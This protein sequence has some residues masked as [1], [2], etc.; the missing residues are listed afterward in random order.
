MILASEGLRLEIAQ[1]DADI[2]AKIPKANKTGK[3]VGLGILGFLL[4]IPWF[5]MDPKNADKTEL[6]AMRVRRSRLA[7]IAGEK[8]CDLLVA[9]PNDNNVDNVLAPWGPMPVVSYKYD[10]V[11]K[12]GSLS[13][14]ISGKGIEARRWIM[15]NIGEICSNQNITLEAGKE[16]S[17]GGYYRIVRESVEDGIMTVEFE[18]AR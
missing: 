16:P 12:Q 17:K 3:N 7:L 18:A 13:V 10:A 6:E 2:A 15:K 1:L 5:F 4:I 9:H 11:S 8:D 14:D